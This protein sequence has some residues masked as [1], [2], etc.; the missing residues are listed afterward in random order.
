M[1]FMDFMGVPLVL[2]HFLVG[3]FPSKSSSYWGTPHDYG[4]PQ[5][6]L[7]AHAASAKTGSIDGAAMAQ[8][9]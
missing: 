4:T 6:V 1:D 8:R 2:I 9:G 7:E 5:V 3:I